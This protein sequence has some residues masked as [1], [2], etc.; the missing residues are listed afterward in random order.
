MSEKKFISQTH[1]VEADTA[2][3]YSQA[4]GELGNFAVQV[5]AQP[6]ET[7][8]GNNRKPHTVAE[9]QRAVRVTGT[10]DRAVGAEPFYDK[11]DEIRA[12]Q[13]QEETAALEEAVNAPSAT[14]PNIEDN[15]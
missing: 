7:Y 5:I 15:K 14:D 2:D 12:R 6:G 3:V 10:V 4:A 9:G 1:K 8:I 13:A 11:V